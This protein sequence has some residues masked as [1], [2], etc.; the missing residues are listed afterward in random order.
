MGQ[1]EFQIFLEISRYVLV[2]RAK[3]RH[4]RWKGA[5]TMTVMQTPEVRAVSGPRLETAAAA[6]MRDLREA[7]ADLVE[8][9][10]GRPA[11]AIDLERALG[12]SKKLAWQVFRIAK[13]ENVG[14]IGNV[15]SPASVRTLLAAGRKR[16]VPARGWERAGAAFEG[17]E[18]FASTQADDRASLVTLVTGTPSAP[19]DPHALAA[20][21]A[22]F[23]GN[24]SIWGAKVEVLARTVIYYPQ[25]APGTATDVSLVIGDMGL[26]RLRESEPLNMVRCLRTGDIPEQGGGGAPG[27]LVA[28]AG[29]GTID[30]GLG[31]LREYCTH[32]LPR[33]VPRAS[34]LG[35]VETELVIAAGRS[36][37][38]TIYSEQFR[39]SA[40]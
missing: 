39:E 22:A 33:M 5:G 15:P 19:G 20:R 12:V 21:K 34:V 29:E 31:L 32:P 2:N 30:H 28:D 40:E 26:Q 4:H 37:A 1:D 36:G 17:F 38:V 7:C 18:R 24:A 13:S 3:P 25:S 27:E 16:G 8:R 23:R 14:E 6:V 35:G 11:R 10:P 9:T